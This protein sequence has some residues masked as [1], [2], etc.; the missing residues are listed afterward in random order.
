MKRSFGFAQD[1]VEGGFAR[2]GG[3]DE[4]A[5]A[6]ASSGGASATLR[7]IFG[8]GYAALEVRP[9]R[10]FLAGLLTRRGSAIVDIITLMENSLHVL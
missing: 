10:H 4:G 3:L 7:A 2:N 6:L 8:C 5:T 9:E 1:E